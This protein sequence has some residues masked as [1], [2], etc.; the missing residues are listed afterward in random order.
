MRTRR[1]MVE[2]KFERELE[3]TDYSANAQS[4]LSRAKCRRLQGMTE[5]PDTLD[6]DSS[7]N[8]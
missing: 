3:V 4:Y 6:S 7:L 1:K 8:A 5:P 2:I